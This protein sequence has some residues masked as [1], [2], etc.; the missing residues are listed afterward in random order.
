MGYM[1]KALREHITDLY[2]VCN[3]SKILDGVEY[4]EPY[5]DGIFYRENKGYDAGAYKDMLCMMLGWDKVYQYDEL[6]LLNDSF[7]GPFYNMKR[8]FGLMENETCDFWG[9]TRNFPGKLIS[10]YHFK[11][12]LQSYFLVFRSDV[13]HS[14][15]FRNFWDEFNYPKTFEEAI[16]N[17]EIKINECLNDKGF[18]SKA[19]TD[20]WGM[21][22]RGDMNP[23]IFNA[24]ELVRDKGL[25][26]LKKKSVIIRNVRFTDAL[27]IIEFLEANNLYPTDW[28]W[29]M[30]DRQFYI[31]GY[32]LKTKNCLEIFY[33]KYNKIYIYGAGLCGR[34]L[35]LYFEHKGWRWESFLVSDKAGQEAECILF[36]DVDID[37]ETGIIVSVL[38]Q[39]ISEEIVEYIGTKCRREQLFIIYDC[40]AMKSYY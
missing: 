8:F 16:I 14:E 2:V 37:D 11:S 15:P 25:P 3:Y 10:G 33:K 34:N 19:F 7:F 36:E 1:L 5:V 22:F 24:L 28:I 6:I 23:C 20:V 18:V 39:D 4:I 9:M 21:T 40:V 29:D 12:H 26:I 27:E 35:A 13:L 17:Y 32:A 31:D 30:M 38:S